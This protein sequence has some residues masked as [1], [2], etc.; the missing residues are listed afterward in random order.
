MLLQ[1]KYQVCCVNTYYL[2]TTTNTLGILFEKK[3][4]SSNFFFYRSIW[5]WKNKARKN[6]I[7]KSAKGQHLNFSE[8]MLQVK[9]FLLPSVGRDGTYQLWAQ[10]ELQQHK[11]NSWNTSPPPPRLNYN[12]WE[13]VKIPLTQFIA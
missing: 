1:G 13:G 5:Y 4:R 2:W 12:M 3:S 6:P 8:H 10:A 9:S 7:G 11:D